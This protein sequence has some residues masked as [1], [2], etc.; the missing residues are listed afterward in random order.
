MTN[1]YDFGS[2]RPK[3]R[4]LPT[5]W[6]KIGGSDFK[7]G[8]TNLFLTPEFRDVFRPGFTRLVYAGASV[9]LGLSCRTTAIPIYRKFPPAPR[10]GSARAWRK[11]G[12]TNMRPTITS[13]AIM[14][15]KRAGIAGIP[16]ICTR[17]SAR[18][19][20]RRFK[21][22]SAALRS[23]CRNRC[24]RKPLTRLSTLKITKG[25]SMNGR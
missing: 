5:D 2:G 1:A 4:K 21:P 11:M 19:R 3:P 22:P 15:T 25:R 6:P 10:T 14:C 16:H 24:R 23:I 9:G 7:P 18:R 17:S 8:P 20:T 12:A 13:K